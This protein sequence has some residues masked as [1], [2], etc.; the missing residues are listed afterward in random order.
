MK[1]EWLVTA[2]ETIVHSY[3]VEAET[4]E[5]AHEKALDGCPNPDAD[6]DSQEFEIV[7]LV[8]AEV[9]T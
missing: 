1:K 9:T 2:H 3:I 8:P 4:E 6:C 7:K 5:Y